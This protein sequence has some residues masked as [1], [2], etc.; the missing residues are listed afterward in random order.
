MAPAQRKRPLA[1][2][3]M[4]ATNGPGRIPEWSHFQKM[5]GG[6]GQRAY[7][8]FRRHSHRLRVGKEDFFGH[9]ANPLLVDP[10]DRV[11]IGV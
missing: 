11:G 1:G 9:F 3:D 6:E 10:Q 2:H 8:Q 5:S 7:R 4:Q